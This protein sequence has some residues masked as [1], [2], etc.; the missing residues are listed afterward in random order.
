MLQFCDCSEEY[1]IVYNI[2]VD[3]TADTSGGSRFLVTAAAFVVVVAGMRAAES[4]LVPF[5][6]SIFIAVIC[7][8]PLYWLQKKKIPSGIAILIVIIGIACAGVL[9]TALIGTS[10]DDFV[11]DVPVYQASLKEK[12]VDILTWFEG[13]GIEVPRQKVLDA[14]N[15]GAAMKLV[16]GLF[17]RITG[18][19]A[20]TFLILMTV[21]FILLE[22]SAISGK[23][24]ALSRRRESP[25]KGFEKFTGDINRYMAIKTGTSLLTGVCV[26]AWLAVLGLNY[27]LLWG[28]LAFLLNFVPNIGSIL[29]AIPAILLALI[30]FGTF[31]TLLIAAGYF[32]V[33]TV[34][35]SII[36][37]KVMGKG[38]GLSPLVVFLSLVFWGWVLGPVGMLLS[39]P[40]TMTVKIALDSS[41]DT[42]HIGV[43]LGPDPSESASG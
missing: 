39:V 41:E 32:V 40:L 11:K 13:I 38:L 3:K 17:S 18:V 12:A 8:P 10:L 4:L 37:P 34:V 7:L 35:G 31:K 26:A 5:L 23:L 22:A 43:L 27:P 2:P 25:G 28:T 16:A 20:N 14:F 33:N 15:P 21:I 9:M 6:I 24:K 36:E 1:R 30:Q 19:F 29:A 42:R